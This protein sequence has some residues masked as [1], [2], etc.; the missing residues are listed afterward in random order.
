MRERTKDV[1]LIAAC[2]LYCG[3]CRLYLQEK[4]E[5]CKKNVKAE[6]WCSVK[7]CCKDKG[8][9]SCADCKTHEDVNKCKK[10]N[11]FISKIFSLIFK[12]DRKW[13]INEIR[14][15][16]YDGFTENMYN[17]GD[18]NGKISKKQSNQ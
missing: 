5:G 16:G 4:C 8:Y 9:K 17:N 3:N 13:C 14:K 18:Y 1:E 15:K 12:S 6:K 10:F 2:G 11:N 7:N